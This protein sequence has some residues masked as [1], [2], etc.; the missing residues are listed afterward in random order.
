MGMNGCAWKTHSWVCMEGT[1]TG[2]HGRPL[3][4]V[5]V[6]SFFNTVLELNQTS[7]CVE[8][9]QIWKGHPKFGAP[10]LNRGA[11]MPILGYSF[12]STSRLKSRISSKLL[13]NAKQMVNSY[14]RVAYNWSK[15]HSAWLAVRPSNYNCSQVQGRSQEFTKRGT[16]QEIWGRKTQAGSRDRIWKP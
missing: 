9:S 7:I 15:L 5:A 8:V 2:L 3:Y 10:P 12:G 11:K 16:H 4:F 6:L 14:E 13:T 1:L